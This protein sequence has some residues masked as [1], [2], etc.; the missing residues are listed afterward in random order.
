MSIGPSVAVFEG[1]LQES[2]E[3]CG[4]ALNL[5]AYESGRGVYVEGAKPLPG[6]Q[7]SAQTVSQS[8]KLKTIGFAHYNH[9]PFGTV[10]G[11]V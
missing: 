3:I 2:E 11:R 7:C 1:D 9:V 5:A 8:A 4:T 6:Y 10:S